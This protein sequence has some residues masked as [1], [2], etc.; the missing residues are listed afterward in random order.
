MFSTLNQ[1]NR[2]NALVNSN[3][4]QSFRRILNCNI[5]NSTDL[6]QSFNLQERYN[7]FLDWTISTVIVSTLL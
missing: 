4:E 2:F 6:F 1:Q 3:V 5:S 7:A